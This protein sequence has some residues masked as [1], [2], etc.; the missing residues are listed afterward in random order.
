M[1][2]LVKMLLVYLRCGVNCG[3]N[4]T[5]CYGGVVMVML[6]EMLVMMVVL[7]VMV[8]VTLGENFTF[9]VYLHIKAKKNQLISFG[10][11]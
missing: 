5:G 2:L 8:V 1:T 7:D 6:V 4:G 9:Q 10:I 11:N 3:I